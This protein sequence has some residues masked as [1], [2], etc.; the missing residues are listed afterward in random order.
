M[1]IMAC[2]AFVAAVL[3]GVL[4]FA[5]GK[6]MFSAFTTLLCG[7]AA[8]LSGGG[9][10]RLLLAGGLFVSVVADW[11]LAHQS[12]RESYFLRG[13]AGFF[14][15]H[16]LFGGYA[17]VRYS[18]GYPQLIAAAVLLAAYSGYL[19]LRV[20][21]GV[22]GLFRLPITAY[23][24]V[25]ILSLYLALSMNAPVFEKVLYAFGIA[26]I[27]FSDTMIAENEFVGLKAAAKL[28]LPTYYLCH[29]LIALSALIR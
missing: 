22:P 18:F 13:V 29:W 11:F 2:I 16:C 1:N 28:V 23:M 9:G 8:A 21:P 20:M 15:A 14:V 3:C 27:L 26:S 19:A 24:L 7:C 6:Y 4:R 17:A 25:S 12:G 10:D 5:T